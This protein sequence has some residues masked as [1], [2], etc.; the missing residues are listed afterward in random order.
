MS[1]P[2]LIGLSRQV[3]GLSLHR[4]GIRAAL[5]GEYRSAFK[6]RG[7]EFDE[8]RPYMAGDDVRN[9]DWRVTARTGK[10]HT[11]LF[12]EERER[13]VFLSVDTRAPMFF[14]TRGVFKFVQAAR[15]AALLAWTALRQ[16]DRVGGQL[17]GAGGSQEFKP[18]HGRKAVLH[19]LQQ[20]VDASAAA[21]A[22]NS[23]TG[24]DE[25]LARLARHARPGSLVVVLSDFRGLT[26]TGEAG[27]IRLHRHCEVALISISD[28]LE[29]RLP[30]AGRLRFGDGRRELTLI[31]SRS[32]VEAHAA[33]Y[34]ARLARVERLSRACGMRHANVSTT[35][36]AW[37]ALRSVL[38]GHPGRAGA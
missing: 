28:P 22:E 23:G 21:P 3:G 37:T 30:A 5:G 15:L 8:T 2:A 26:S 1:L 35:D 25:A 6:G 7:M 20:L 12:R 27:L 34:A 14:A 4:S 32:V 31:S 16:S 18:E 13:P 36:E 29:R 33:N 24:M 38:H 11:K 17:F 10:A 9:L 19:F